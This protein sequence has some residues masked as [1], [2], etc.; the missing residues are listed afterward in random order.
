MTID[1]L[2]ITHNRMPFH[3]SKMF[4]VYSFMRLS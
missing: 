4:K 1:I 3:I 2:V